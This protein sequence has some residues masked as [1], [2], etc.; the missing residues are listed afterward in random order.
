MLFSKFL[1]KLPLVLL[2]TNVIEFNGIS[3][4]GKVLR[5]FNTKKGSITNLSGFYQGHV[6]RLNFYFIVLHRLI[7]FLTIVTRVIHVIKIFI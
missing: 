5:E 1:K 2:L 4:K 6:R 3:L 7:K